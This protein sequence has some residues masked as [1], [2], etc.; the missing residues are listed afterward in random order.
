L[1]N[2]KRLGL[3]ADS[4]FIHA[5]RELSKKTQKIQQKLLLLGGFSF[6]FGSDT[7]HDLEAMSSTST[8]TECKLQSGRAAERCAHLSPQFLKFGSTRDPDLK[9]ALLN[10]FRSLAPGR[11]DG[12]TLDLALGSQTTHVISTRK[13]PEMRTKFRKMLE[14]HPEED[15]I[16]ATLTTLF[17]A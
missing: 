3:S 6:S 7:G 11:V 17:M 13:Q 12:G 16:S 15:K 5:A 2:L 9:T 14:T 8:K 4:K 10:S 1:R